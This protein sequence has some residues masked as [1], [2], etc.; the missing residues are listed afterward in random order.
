MP[1]LSTTDVLYLRP[2]ADGGNLENNKRCHTLIRFDSYG[3]PTENV[4]ITKTWPQPTRFA[5]YRQS[6]W[7]FQT[8][9]FKKI[10]QRCFFILYSKCPCQRFSRVSSR[11]RNGR[12]MRQNSS[13]RLVLDLEKL[14]SKVSSLKWLRKRPKFRGIPRLVLEKAE[15]KGKIPRLVSSLT[16]EKL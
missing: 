12:G 16:S 10:T 4:R 1:D 7:L 2:C 14:G 6:F 11:P 9:N 13:P 8:C 15:E 3:A 5:I